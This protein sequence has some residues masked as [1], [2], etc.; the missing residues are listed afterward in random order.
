MREVQS[1]RIDSQSG[2][3]GSPASVT[4]SLVSWEIHRVMGDA[5]NATDATASRN[6]KAHVVQLHSVYRV[7]VGTQDDDGGDAS[8]FWQHTTMPDLA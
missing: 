7:G 3:S 1:V 6:R 2:P 8:T 4:D 5:T